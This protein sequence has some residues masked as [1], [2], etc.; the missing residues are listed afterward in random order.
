M[1]WNGS[2]DPLGTS[3]RRAIWVSV[4]DALVDWWIDHPEEGPQQMTDRGLRLFT[5]VFG[6]I[7]IDAWSATSEFVPPSPH[8][9]V[10]TDPFA[11]PPASARGTRT[12]R[13]PVKIVT[14][15]LLL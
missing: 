10:E 8:E 4:F 2:D 15:H 5:S 14:T 11:G 3:A 7:D 12:Q 9:S 13:L 6:P 1:R